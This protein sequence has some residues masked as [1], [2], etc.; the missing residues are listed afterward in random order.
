MSL[1]ASRSG[2]T[3][4]IQYL[5]CTDLSLIGS[6]SIGH[7]LP[8]SPK[9]LNRTSIIVF[10]LFVCCF[11]FKKGHFSICFVTIN[12]GIRVLHAHAMFFFS[13]TYEFTCIL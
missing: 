6:N 12:K 10:C 13:W 5:N 3:H 7:Q 11:F 4:I 8:V 1:M 2:Q 9:N